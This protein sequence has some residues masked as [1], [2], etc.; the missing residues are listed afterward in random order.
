[1]LLVHLYLS[2]DLYNTMH[3]FNYD[4][5]F[6]GLSVFSLLTVGLNVNKFEINRVLKDLDRHI[7]NSKHIWGK[8]DIFY[9]SFNE[10]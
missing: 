5:L 10:R 7:V 8:L 2:Y 9:R 4:I 1:M 3:K 6:R